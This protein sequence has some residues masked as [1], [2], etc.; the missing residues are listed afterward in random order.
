MKLLVIASGALALG[1]L[2]AGPASAQTKPFCLKQSATGQPSCIYD[3]MASCEAA[4]KGDQQAQ[5]VQRSDSPGTTGAAPSPGSPS[6]G[7]SSPG[8]PGSPGMPQR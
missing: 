8:G 4:K 5:C 1:L 3:T 6:P 2:A 7:S